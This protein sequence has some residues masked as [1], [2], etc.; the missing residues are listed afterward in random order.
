MST[1]PTAGPE[2]SGTTDVSN[3]DRNITQPTD[4]PAR[5]DKLRGHDQYGYPT[6]TFFR[7]RVCGEE[8]T[9]RD[10]VVNG[11]DCPR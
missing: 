7:C 5:V 10:A 1:Y 8:G 2:S 6:Y 9:E 11:C 3:A 4:L